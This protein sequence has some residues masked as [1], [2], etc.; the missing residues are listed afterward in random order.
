MTH[1]KAA[2][3][4]IITNDDPNLNSHNNASH[5]S[6]QAGDRNKENNQV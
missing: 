3:S 6:M 5:V 4:P 2:L 1:K